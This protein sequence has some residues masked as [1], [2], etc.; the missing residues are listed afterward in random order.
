MC[1]F[2]QHLNQKREHKQNGSSG[3][4]VV[5][6]VAQACSLHGQDA[7]PSSDIQLSYHHDSGRT[8]KI[9]GVRPTPSCN[10]SESDR[11]PGR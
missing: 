9:C 8:S 6:T 10:V 4:F 11:A 3:G 1:E 5:E 7:R 2:N